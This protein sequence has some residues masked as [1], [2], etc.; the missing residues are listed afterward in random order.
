[1]SRENGSET[2]E[3]GGQNGSVY[4]ASCKW[5]VWRVTWSGSRNSEQSQTLFRNKVQKTHESISYAFQESIFNVLCVDFTLLKL[6]F[7]FDDFSSERLFS[8]AFI[9]T[10]IIWIFNRSVDFSKIRQKNCEIIEIHLRMIEMI[11]RF[12]RRKWYLS[13]I[14]TISFLSTV[15]VNNIARHWRIFLFRVRRSL[16]EP[17]IGF[18]HFKLMNKRFVNADLS[19]SIFE[20][21]KR[22]CVQSAVRISWY[23]ERQVAGYW[24]MVA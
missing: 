15:M 7:R 6:F 19:S 18:F 20:Y 10:R 2:D 12:N 14:S 13:V 24:F 5:N 21:V 9:T 11:I 8:C 1:M 3:T 16:K 17:M 23:L 4:S 22:Q